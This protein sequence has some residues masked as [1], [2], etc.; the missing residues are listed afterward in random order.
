MTKNKINNYKK[1]RLTGSQRQTQILQKA[2]DLCSRKGFAG[3]TLDEIARKSGISR[4]LIVQHFGSKKGLY[5]ALIDYL[6]KSHPM[7]DDPDIKKYMERRDD[8]GVF[9]GYSQHALRYMT[10]DNKHSPL[11]LI[12]FS[13]LEKPDLYKRHYQQ[14]R[15]KGQAVLEEYISKRIEDGTFQEVNPKHVSVAF[16]AMLIQ[17]LIQEITVPRFDSEET[18]MS[19]IDT[20]INLLIN[21]LKKRE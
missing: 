3:S 18:F 16:S 13:M 15:L 6:F 20:M 19:C 10:K 11:R 1:Q 17:L 8:Y 2:Q 4:A 7:E 12:L 14:R 21:G 9:K 5:E